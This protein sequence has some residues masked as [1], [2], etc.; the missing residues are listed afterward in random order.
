MKTLC[1]TKSLKSTFATTICIGLSLCLSF[2]ALAQTASPIRKKLIA[3]GWDRP[4][5]DTFRKNIKIME[6]TPYDGVILTVDGRDDNN[7]YVSASRDN[8]ADKP[9]KKEWFQKAINDLK[10]V[11]SSKL[12]DNFIQTSAT[13]GD[14]DWFDDAGWKVIIENYRIIAEIAKEGNLKGI[15]FDAEPYAKFY[16]QFTYAFQ[17][18]HGEHSFAEYQDKA[19][20][21]G[22]EM[23]EAIA[24]VDPNLVIFTYFMNSSNAGAAYTAYPNAALESAQYG[25]YPAFING[26]LD[27]APATMQFVDGCES[28]GYR[29]NDEYTFLKTA[30]LVRNGALNL[31][32]PENREKYLAQVQTSFGIYLDAYANPSTS[33]WYIDPKGSTPAQRLKTNITY[34]AN[35]S[36]EYVWTWGEKYRRWPVEGKAVA[37]V[38]AEYWE[39]V[40]PG[41]NDAFTDVF[42]PA[43]TDISQRISAL[44]NDKTKTDLLTNG[45][46][47]AVEKVT[48]QKSA[49][50]DWNTEGAPANWSTWQQKNSTGT[51][52]QDNKVNHSGSTGGAIRLSGV[53]NG[54]LIQAIDVKPGATYLIRGWMRQTG[55]GM[56]FVWV[57]WQHD[58][59]FVESSASDSM[60]TGKPT[61]KQDS[62]KK[63]EGIATVPEGAS[64]LVVLLY[65]MR[66]D[67]AED[68]I[69]YDDLQIYKI[70]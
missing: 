24:S 42:H 51:F 36:T 37:Q 41:I 48:G 4:G 40:L 62:W 58:G 45:N 25:L 34:A 56:G 47:S 55:E 28:K 20:Q 21:R 18:Q 11:H 30:E 5:A 59:Q 6:K 14:V 26:W 50:A 43:T 10:A 63:I 54:S 16:R 15:L 60:M 66:Q 44:L 35:A 46:F 23:I 1:K 19:R 70:P 57:R 8:F 68:N 7:K 39:E 67:S 17:E 49:R 29:A 9:L 33:R 32:A 69:W 38:K 52:T 64:K 53:R 22:K 65:A 61:D 12:T 31:V 13:P 3:A 2:F 27:G